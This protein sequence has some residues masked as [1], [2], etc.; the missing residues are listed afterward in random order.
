MDIDLAK[1]IAYDP[2]TG[3]LTWIA[4]TGPR[5]QIDAEIGHI[6]AAGY[7]R[8]KI[9]GRMYFA[10][11]LAW[12]LSYGTWPAH[13]IDH[14]DGN[15]LNNKLENLRDVPKIINQRNARKRKDNRS[16]LAGV[17]EIWHP[18]KYWVAQW[19]DGKRKNKWFS[20][21]K[22]GDAQAKQ[23]AV[24]YRKARI[25]EIGGYTE[26]H[27]DSNEWIKERSA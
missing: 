2:V 20:V 23:M 19:F 18:T 5:G 16:G 3:R 15:P 10:H 27:G 1:L 9:K 17:C 6:T 11:R 13:E 25:E 14:I 24:A 7:R 12:F 8:V 4:R 21:D 26:R 22:Y